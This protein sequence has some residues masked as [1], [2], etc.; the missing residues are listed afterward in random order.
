MKAIVY[1]FI[2]NLAKQAVEPRIIKKMLQQELGYSKG[3]ADCY[4][5]EYAQFPDG[6]TVSG[7]LCTLQG[8]RVKESWH[9]EA[10][11]M[12]VKAAKE[13]K[14]LGLSVILIAD[15]LNKSR[16]AIY[17]LVYKH[18]IEFKLKGQPGRPLKATDMQKP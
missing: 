1:N 15:K 12:L 10:I 6:C 18:K 11:N 16:S 3:T 9:G 2:N 5:S 7:R 17:N 14:Q 4:W 8:K 13:E